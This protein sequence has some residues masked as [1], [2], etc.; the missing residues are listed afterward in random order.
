MP[1]RE[2]HISVNQTARYCTLGDPA[3]A[4]QV[5]FVLH[6][7]GQLVPYFIRHFAPLDDGNRLIVAP[8]GLSRFYLERTSWQSAGQARVGATWMTREAREADIAD[9]VAYL[10]RLYQQVFTSVTRESVRVVVLGFSQGVAT[11]CRWLA[12]GSARAESLVLWAG[13]LPPDLGRDAAARLTATKIIRV[14]GDNDD[15]ASAE[16]VTAENALAERLGI[17]ATLVRFAGGHEIDAET[18]KGLAV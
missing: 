16:A 12:L 18:L 11:A 17:A 5:W 3:R 10:D 15:M 4:S 13:P 14:V 7:Y 8:E 9:N 1:A 2:H 6:G